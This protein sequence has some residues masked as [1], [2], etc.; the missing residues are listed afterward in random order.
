V[1][2]TNTKG[3]TSTKFIRTNIATGEVEDL[4]NT[5]KDGVSF[6]SGNNPEVI[7]IDDLIYIKVSTSLNNGVLVIE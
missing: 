7:Q 1:V 5:L 2:T 3:E 6:E 4:S